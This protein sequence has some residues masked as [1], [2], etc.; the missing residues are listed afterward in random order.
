[1]SGGVNCRWW[2]VLGIN[3]RQA[4]PWL[5]AH[6]GEERTRLFASFASPFQVLSKMPLATTEVNLHTP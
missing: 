6:L 3:L 2:C 4:C 1:M 5:D